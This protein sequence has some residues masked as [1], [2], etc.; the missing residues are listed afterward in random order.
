MSV[1]DSCHVYLPQERRC[2][3]G[4]PVG[5]LFCETHALFLAQQPDSKD[6]LAALERELEQLRRELEA[7]NGSPL[8]IGQKH[9]GS[10]EGGL[11]GS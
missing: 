3:L 10:F 6:A 5:Q 4:K 9:N 7:E 2:K 1:C 8:R 11:N